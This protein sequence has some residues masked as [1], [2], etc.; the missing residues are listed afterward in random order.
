MKNASDIS[1]EIAALAYEILCDEWGESI[2]IRMLT[3]TVSGLID[4]SSSY[5]QLDLFSSNDSLPRDKDKKREETVDEIRRKFGSAA[6]S[7]GALY[8]T[9]IGVG[10]KKK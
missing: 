6:I 5:T 7:T 2:P 10:V 4:A 3:V 1:K 9:D 8:D